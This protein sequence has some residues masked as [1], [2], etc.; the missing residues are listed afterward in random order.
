MHFTGPHHLPSYFREPWSELERVVRELIVA[1][2]RLLQAGVEAMPR[3]YRHLEPLCQRAVSLP[4]TPSGALFSRDRALLRLWDSDLIREF[5]NTPEDKI[6]RD[7]FTEQA[8]LIAASLGL[9][10]ELTPYLFEEL[11]LIFNTP[12]EV[13]FFHEETF[14]ATLD[15]VMLGQQATE[16]VPLLVEF[17]LNGETSLGEELYE[18]HAAV[19]FAA[20]LHTVWNFFPSLPAADQTTLLNRFLYRAVVA[21]VP[22]RAKLAETLA[23][24]GPNAP[25]LARQWAESLFKS[26]QLIPTETRH[27]NWSPLSL[28]MSSYLSSAAGVPGGSFAQERF[29]RGLYQNQPGRDTYSGWLR[30][31]I[32]I[33][34][35]LQ[36]GNLPAA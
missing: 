20:L 9:N 10:R 18:W 7:A 33:I 29:S 1:K 25:G 22:V 19:V 34:V 16:L 12:N 27:R 15:R 31:V 23:L 2:T 35:H 5:L 3:L 26:H 24:T 21:G 32:G 28:T 13:D 36:G 30:E 4:A 6:I 8:L 14:V 17:L 11:L